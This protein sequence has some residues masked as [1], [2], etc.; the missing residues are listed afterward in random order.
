VRGIDPRR[1][2]EQVDNTAGWADVP[3]ARAVLSD[4]DAAFRAWELKPP[5]LPYFRFLLAAHFTTVATFVP[6]DVD[7]RIRHH[8]FESLGAEELR[9]ACD[10][11][12]EAAG[13]DV[14]LV[15]ARTVE[16]PGL[17][18][19]SGHA[20]EWFS[21]RAGALGRA[22]LIGDEGLCERLVSAI[23]EELDRERRMLAALVTE[24]ADV[25]VLRASTTIA[26]NL[27]DLSRVVEAW[28][29]ALAA[30]PLRSRYMRLGH[31][32]GAHGDG[33]VRAGT[34]NK[35]VMAD[36]NHRFLALRKPRA[37]RSSR[38][39]L[40]PIGPFFDAWGRTIATHPAL[41]DE[42]RAEVVAALLA[43]HDGY[44]KQAGCLRALAGIDANFGGGLF[45]L[46]PDLPARMRRL[47]SSGP[48]RD[49]LKTPEEVFVAR[50]RKRVREHFPM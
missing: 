24:K 49:A 45:K 34:L 33:F 14:R 9:E 13:W 25:D 39:L 23:D 19:L 31:V 22:A 11:A 1:L 41:G 47:L 15:S 2:K 17:G 29:N 40:L 28:P 35:A 38:D 26:H 43:I 7:A 32:P 48:L 36:E 10:I 18:V 16:R 3:G 6:T 30:S 20:G 44:P 46:E 37:L 4:V 5:G 27:G 50:L 8:T 12:D 42:D 21:V